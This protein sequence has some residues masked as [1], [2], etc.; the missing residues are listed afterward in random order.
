MLFAGLSLILSPQIHV[1]HK[2]GLSLGLALVFAYRHYGLR[3]SRWFFNALA[4]IGLAGSLIYG[5]WFAEFPIQAAFYFLGYLILIRMFELET[6]RDYKFALILSLFEI[7]AGSL[8]M[9][10]LRYLF[11]FA[12][13]LFSAL[14]SLTLITIS[15]PGSLRKP[16]PSANRLLSLLGSA[17]LFCMI[18]GFLLFFLLPRVGISL[19]NFHIAGY[20]AWTGYSSEIHLGEVSELLQNSAPVLRGRLLGKEGPIP[21]LKWR[22]RAVDHYENNIWEDRSSSKGSFPISYNQP[23]TIDLRPPAG[24]KLPQEI[25]LEPD[26]GV[27]LPA[28]GWPYAYMLPVMFKSFS[29]SVNDY[30]SLPFASTERIHYLA[31]S[32]L[33]QYSEP[34]LEQA[35]SRLPEY[36]KEKKRLRSSDLLQLPKGSEPVCEL[37]REVVG[38]EPDPRK[39]LSLLRKFFQDKFKYSLTDLPTGERP[40]EE[41]LLRSRRGNCEYFASAGVLMLRCLGI[42]SRMALGFIGGEWN[43]YQNYYLV[44]QSDAHAWAE[45]YLPGHGFLE[46]DPTPAG[47]RPLLRGSSWLWRL[48]DPVIFRWNRWIVEYSVSDQ[49]R[50]WRRMEAESYRLRYNLRLSLPSLRLWLKGKPS[51]AIIIVFLGAAGILLS[52]WLS[53][54]RRKERT[55]L[56]KL[57]PEQRRAVKLYLRM[58]RILRKQG[59]TRT[60][61]TTGLEIAAQSFFRAEI[62]NRIRRITQLYYEIR[63]GRS[64][65]AE[66]ELKSA[67]AQLEE[68]EQFISDGR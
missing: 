46:F 47:A 14:F 13:W 26:L 39:K 59:F 65:T 50:G 68:L 63:F 57:G 11:I 21:G 15:D 55:R 45:I 40:L 30:C 62:R 6:T 61:S 2:L 31:Y 12:G 36:A 52:F 20:R 37:A 58:F 10:Q 18:M 27:D 8:M 28:V 24:E 22:M 67:E 35:F 4:I 56:G 34:E 53:P 25:Y 38:R 1:A 41:F 17:G 43:P 42:P 51:L 66:A 29:C 60:P 5:I 32:A 49:L 3:V 44:R 7:S 9:V 64:G 23:V 33:P 48:L 19:V 16:L 54:S